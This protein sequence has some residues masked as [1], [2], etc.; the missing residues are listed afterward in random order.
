MF[1]LNPYEKGKGASIFRKTF[2]PFMFFITSSIIVISCK[3]KDEVSST[4]YN[5]EDPRIRSVVFQ[6]YSNNLIV[7]DVENT[8]FNYDSLTYGTDKTK[9]KTYFY[10][11]TSQPSILYKEEEEKE[12]HTF[13]NGSSLDLSNPIEILSL[14][15]D[16]SNSKKYKF[17]LRVHKYDVSA[18]TWEEFAKIDIDEPII[19]RKA[20]VF[21]NSYQWFCSV[22]SGKQYRFS[23]EDGE[24]WQRNEITSSTPLIWETLSLLNDSLWCQSGNGEIFVASMQEL[25]FR[26]RGGLNSVD[27]LLFELDGRLWAVIDD[28]LYATPSYDKTNTEPFAFK[29]ITALPKNFPLDNVIPFTAASGFTQVGYM[30]STKEDNG[31][32]WSIDYKG[33]FMQLVNEDNKLPYLEKPMVYIY[34][35]TLG[36]VGGRKKNGEYSDKCYA[37]YNSGVS[38]AEDWHKNLNEQLVGLQNAGVFVCNSLGELLIVGG[39]KE[40]K[41]DQTVCSNIVWKGVLNAII[42][43]ENNYSEK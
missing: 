2:F 17:D 11:Y 4:D 22:E 34:G 41:D 15:Q 43:D 7:N 16:G 42:A 23:S 38:W 31:I 3:D 30:Y 33:A 10:G 35:N 14:S 37:S 28:S 25:E 36:I 6:D 39:N 19:S 40:R 9:I 29:P 21:D 13:I 26:E 5:L 20:L 12:W 27:K 8:I 32:I 24:I 18:F 1:K